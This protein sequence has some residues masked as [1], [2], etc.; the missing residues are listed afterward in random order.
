MLV[1]YFL[2]VAHPDYKRPSTQIIT[3]TC[4][5]NVLKKR[6]LED[7]LQFYIDIFQ[8][9]RGYSSIEQL[10]ESYYSTYYMDQPPI[11]AKY[12]DLE[13]NKWN[14]FYFSDEEFFKMYKENYD[15]DTDNSTD[16]SE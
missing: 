8:S 10:E 15:T 12:F 2:A 3:K 13:S 14:D 16:E 1:P 11:Y 4:D 9:L 5:K 7:I 6:I